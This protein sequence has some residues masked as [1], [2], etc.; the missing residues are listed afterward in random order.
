MKYELL[1]ESSFI[2][3]N[4]SKVSGYTKFQY[5]IEKLHYGKKIQSDYIRFIISSLMNSKSKK[6]KKDIFYH[7]DNSEKYSKNWWLI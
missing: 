3:I 6:N 1:K 2:K 4:N 5:S 7:N